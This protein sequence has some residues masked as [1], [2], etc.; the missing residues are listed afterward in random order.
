MI[1]VF[2]FYEIRRAFQILR[3]QFHLMDVNIFVEYLSMYPVQIIRRRIGYFLERLDVSRKIL[4]KIRVGEKGYSPLYKNCP[5]KGRLND[6][7][8]VIV[9]G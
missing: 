3:D 7:W 6:R 2:E 9:N 8:R 5:Q 1:D 4:N